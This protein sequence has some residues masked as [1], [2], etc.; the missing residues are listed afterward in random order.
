MEC[1]LTCSKITKAPQDLL[2]LH[3]EDKNGRL[4]ITS[5]RDVRKNKIKYTIKK[6]SSKVPPKVLEK[7]VDK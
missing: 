1:L 3:F 7:M 5:I 6:H 4:R 2:N